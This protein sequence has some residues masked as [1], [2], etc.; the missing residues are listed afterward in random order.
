MKRQFQ[1]KYTQ[2]LRSYFLNPEEALLEQAYRLGKELVATRHDI[3]DIAEMHTLALKQ[4]AQEIPDSS[5]GDQRGY[6]P[7]LE[8]LVAY[9]VTLRAQAE[10]LER[11]AQALEGEIAERRRAEE[12]L[13]EYSERL[14]EMVEERTQELRDAQD[15]LI[16]QEKLATLGQ[17]AGAMGHELRNPLGAISNAAYYLN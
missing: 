16:R 9:D 4:L 8:V 10:W 15:Q 3:E 5:I 12:A 17:L 14:E 7:L 13:E 6:L 1:E 2:L 11:Q